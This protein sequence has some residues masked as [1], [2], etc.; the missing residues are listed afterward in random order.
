MQESTTTK[1]DTPHGALLPNSLPRLEGFMTYYPIA[2]NPVTHTNHNPMK[3]TLFTDSYWK[4]IWKGPILDLEYYATSIPSFLL[5][6]NT[7]TPIATRTYFHLDDEF[8]GIPYRVKIYE[9]NCPQSLSIQCGT[10]VDIN[11]MNTLHSRYIVDYCQLIRNGHV[12]IPVHYREY[13]GQ[14]FTNTYDLRHPSFILE[15]P[16]KFYN[17]SRLSI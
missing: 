7:K 5:L 16:I 14:K 8:M 4:M 1:S 17:P 10:M 11:G 6:D 12:Y 9:E 2:T 3:F 15:I 13:Y